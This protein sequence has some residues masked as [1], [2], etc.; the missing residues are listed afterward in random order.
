MTA[1][2]NTQQVEYWNGLAGE[3]WARLHEKI[4]LHVEEITAAALEFAAPREGERIL[5]LGCGCGTTTF[6]LAL[7]A[8]RD[9]TGRGH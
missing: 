1:S 4:D 6:L 8:G 2:P 3:R 7:R 9:G 5:D